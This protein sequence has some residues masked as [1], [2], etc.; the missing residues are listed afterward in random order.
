LL[1]DQQELINVLVKFQDL[2][3]CSPL[4]FHQEGADPLG[5]DGLNVESIGKFVLGFLSFDDILYVAHVHGRNH[6][7]Q[8]VLFVLILVELEVEVSG[9]NAHSED[10]VIELILAILV[11]ESNVVHV[12]FTFI[13]IFIY[14][15]VYKQIAV[16]VVDQ[17]AVHGVD[18]F[19]RAVE[20]EVHSEVFYLVAEEI[21]SFGVFPE[22]ETFE[23]VLLQRRTGVCSKGA[24]HFEFVKGESSGL[25]LDD[26]SEFLELL[27][28]ELQM[29]DLSLIL[30]GEHESYFLSDI[31]MLQITPVCSH[32][33]RHFLT[34]VGL[35]NHEETGVH[36]EHFSGNVARIH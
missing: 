2:F 26:D 34:T 9:E 8:L 13:Q 5:R 11:F 28:L 24:I 23:V 7:G 25:R 18:R 17:F 3:S 30:F 20:D 29:V 27:S 10:I 32:V 35:H 22:R 36:L 14:L 12:S 33:V 19:G 31:D 21:H 15:C 1:F 16:R 6:I 4:E